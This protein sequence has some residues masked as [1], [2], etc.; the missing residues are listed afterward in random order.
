MSGVLMVPP[1][2]T[3]P[4]SKAIRNHHQAA[5]AG[6]AGVVS[7]TPDSKA[8]RNPAPD[9]DLAAD[10]LQVSTTPDSKAIRNR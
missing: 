2:S 4:D 3:T 9:T 5:G 6:G 1:V 10:E 7:T 8:I